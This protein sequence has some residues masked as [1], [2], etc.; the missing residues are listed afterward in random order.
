[1]IKRF[2]EWLVK[3]QIGYLGVRDEQQTA[4]INQI[5]VKA[6]ILTYSLLSVLMMIS[7]VWDF[8][9]GRQVTLGTIFLIVVQCFNTIYTTYQIRKTAVDETEF[10]DRKAYQIAVRRLKQRFVVRGVTWAVGLFIWLTVL[11]PFLKHEPMTAS[12]SMA[13]WFSATGVVVGVGGY[14]TQKRR[15]HLYL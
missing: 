8:H 4:T 13:I 7:L 9:Q 3:Q 1:M 10:Y 2:E 6:N 11:I 12:L 14:F 15:L 5:L